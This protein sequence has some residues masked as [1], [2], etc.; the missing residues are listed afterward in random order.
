MHI[1]IL[2]IDDEPIIRKG[3]SYLLS[4]TEIN[5]AHIEVVESNGSLNANQLLG[6]QEFDIIFTDIRMPGMDGLTFIDQW[7]NKVNQ[8]QWVILSGYDDFGYAQKA[9]SLGVK[10][11]ILKPITKKN[12]K[13][14]LE[15][16]IDN[17]RKQ[18]N[19][20]IG[21][22]E[23]EKVRIK[24]EEAIW[25]LDEDF[26]VSI[27][28]SW[29]DEIIQR[30]I[31]ED[32]YIRT[33]N[34]LFANL[35]QRVNNRGRIHIEDQ[36]VTITG[37]DT[38]VITENFQAACIKLMEHIRLQRKGQVLDPIEFAKEFIQEN[39][40]KKLTLDDV[41]NRIGL[42][43]TYF[44][45][46][47]K[48]ETG[49]SFIDFRMQLRMEKAKELIETGNM[50]ITDIANSIGYEDLSHFTKTF[51]KYTGYSPSKYLSIMENN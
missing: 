24:L 39:L 5:D 4:H 3:L 2:I 34:D 32:Y 13:D 33:L 45:H 35:L 37:K 6:K 12:V 15:R 26:A 14:T 40:D 42:N 31:A 46:L 25:T 23:L 38:S 51:K 11:Y 8:T 41:A 20:F 48:K 7:K 21:M 47:F 10:E 49:I 27:I 22:D 17:H 28:T 36:E 18:S 43:A 50:K 1:N 29:Y 9:I 16:L 19:N 30:E 44:S